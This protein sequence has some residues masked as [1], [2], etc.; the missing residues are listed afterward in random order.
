MIFYF[1]SENLQEYIYIVMA[2]ISKTPKYLLFYGHTGYMNDIPYFSSGSCLNQ[3][4]SIIITEK[5]PIFNKFAKYEI[6]NITGIHEF[7]KIV[8]I[9]MVLL[10]IFLRSRFAHV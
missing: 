8:Q 4:I 3:R 6:L 1:L 5:S 10:H 7:F 9:F 2:F